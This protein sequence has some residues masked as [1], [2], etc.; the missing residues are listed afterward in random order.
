M[1][2]EDIK[3]LEEIINLYRNTNELPY[4]FN[5]DI[6][7]AIE[8]LLEENRIL[9]NKQT[10]V[11]ADS[12]HKKMAEKFDEDFITKSKLIEALENGIS[13]AKGWGCEDGAYCVKEEFEKLGILGGDNNIYDFNTEKL[14]PSNF[15]KDGDIWV[16]KIK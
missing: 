8:N 12:F 4:R 2:N 9:K 15:G 1:N 7:Q 13:T 5:G 10:K 16:Q 3:V 11:I 14:P 6:I